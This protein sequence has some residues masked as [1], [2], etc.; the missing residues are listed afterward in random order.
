MALLDGDR[1]E[2]K[3]RQAVHTQTADDLMRRMIKEQLVK[4]D[5]SP[6][7]PERLAYTMSYNLSDKEAELYDAV[8]NYVREEFNR[9][10]QLDDS[11]K[12]KIQQASCVADR[13]AAP[14]ASSPEAIYQS[15]VRRRERLQTRLD[16]ARI[17]KQADEARLVR[18]ENESQAMLDDID[19]GLATDFEE[20]EDELA[21]R[22]TAALNLRELKARRSAPGTAG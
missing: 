1:F 17:G 21:D 10:E 9:A 2:G 18:T 13:I 14:T 7:F 19:E 15:L 4:M 11:R 3:Y 6:L 8:T 16:E 20:K 5:G 12:R 22:T